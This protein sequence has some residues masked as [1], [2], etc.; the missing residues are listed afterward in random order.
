M[1]R[2]VVKTDGDSAYFPLTTNGLIEYLNTASDIFDT[3]NKPVF[4]DSLDRV[5]KAVVIRDGQLVLITGENDGM[6]YLTESTQ[7]EIR[8][9]DDKKR[10]PVKLTT[11][12]L[13]AQLVMFADIFKVEDEP[14]MFG[15]KHV[16]GVTI[17]EGKLVLLETQ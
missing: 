15:D 2:M 7:M 6:S 13:M 14:I 1:S 8:S 4:V 9:M 16:G 10:N 3:D 5:I 11:S 12:Q 17:R